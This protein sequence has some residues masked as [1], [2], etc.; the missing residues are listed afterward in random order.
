MGFAPGSAGRDRTGVTALGP[1]PAGSAEQARMA[2]STG[3]VG[4]VVWLTMLPVGS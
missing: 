2:A 1:G 4:V 3:P